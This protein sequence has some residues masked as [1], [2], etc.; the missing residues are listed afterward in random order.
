M[1]PGAANQ[2]RLRLDRPD[3]QPRP[4]VNRHWLMPAVT[5]KTHGGTK[6]AEAICLRSSLHYRMPP[7]ECALLAD[8]VDVVLG[9]RAHI[10]KVCRQCVPCQRMVGRPGI[11]DHQRQTSRTGVVIDERELPQVFVRGNGGR[12]LP[13][14]VVDHLGRL[15]AAGQQRMCEHADAEIRPA[16]VDAQSAV[17][18]TGVDAR[19]QC[20]TQQFLLVSL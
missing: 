1:M 13:D 17:V 11:V 20:F 5:H 3:A 15:I 18:A 7:S 8:I 12:I 6:N 16:Q 14:G 19:N 2:F 9:G 4:S 10:G